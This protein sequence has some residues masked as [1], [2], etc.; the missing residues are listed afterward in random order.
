MTQ[1]TESTYFCEYIYLLPVMIFP[2]NVEGLFP[3]NS[4]VSFS[5]DVFVFVYIE[6]IS[7]ISIVLNRLISVRAISSIQ[8][9]NQLALRSTFNKSG[10]QSKHT[11]VRTHKESTYFL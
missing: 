6:F 2:L 8:N 9:N 10:L 7:A 3:L 11:D 5:C 1:E 4:G